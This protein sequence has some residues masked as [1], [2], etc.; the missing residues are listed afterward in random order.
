MCI[1]QTTTVFQFVVAVGV[2]GQG[3]RLAPLSS[4]QKV[5]SRHLARSMVCEW[6]HSQP[7]SQIC[8]PFNTGLSLRKQQPKVTQSGLKEFGLW[9]DLKAGLGP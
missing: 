3:P 6:A 7:R 2:W 5:S 9:S 8:G 1:N 4:A